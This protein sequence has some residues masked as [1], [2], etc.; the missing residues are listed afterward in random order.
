[1]GVGR[2]QIVSQKSLVLLIAVIRIAAAHPLS[3]EARSPKAHPA[4][5]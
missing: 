2:G 1:M 4:G 3:L 5:L